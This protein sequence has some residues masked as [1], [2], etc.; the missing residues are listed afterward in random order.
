[1]YCNIH[2]QMV[3]FV[4]VVDSGFVALTGPDGS[5]RFK[6]VPAGSHLVKAWHEEATELSQP[7]AVQAGGDATLVLRLDISGAS[8][9]PHK[10]KYGKDY[11]PQA[12]ETDDERY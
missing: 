11:K 8:A 4:M 1:V 3:G 6:D 2:P 10:N 9:Q 7:V 12:G 5:F